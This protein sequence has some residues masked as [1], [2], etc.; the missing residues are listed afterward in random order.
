MEAISVNIHSIPSLTVV[1]LSTFPPRMWTSFILKIDSLLIFIPQCWAILD[2]ALSPL[3]RGGVW[4]AHRWFATP[5]PW[6]LSVHNIWHN[7]LWIVGNLWC[8]NSSTHVTYTEN[9]STSVKLSFWIK[10]CSLQDPKNLPEIIVSL[11]P[12]KLI[13]SRVLTED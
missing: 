3:H 1:G 6:G 8:I 9:F 11:E 10:I 12:E 4:D 13:W 7:Q 2:I 5:N